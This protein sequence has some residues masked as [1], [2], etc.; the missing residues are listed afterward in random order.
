M[1]DEDSSYKMKDSVRL[2][3]IGSRWRF[4]F[5]IPQIQMLRIFLAIS[6]SSMKE[7]IFIDPMH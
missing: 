1:G 3:R 5:D 6:E 7:I 4:V 2:R